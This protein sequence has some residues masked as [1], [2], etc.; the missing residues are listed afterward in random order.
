VTAGT[1]DNALLAS[2]E[3]VRAAKGR[4]PAI[5][6][7]SGT[8]L[9]TFAEI[10]DEGTA[11]AQQCASLPRGTIIALQLGNSAS[12]PAALLAV[13]RHELIA[14]PIGRHMERHETERA[15]TTATAGAIWTADGDTLRLEQRPGVL[16]RTWTGPT[17]H[18]LKLTSGTTS[19]PR[20]VRFRTPQ[21]LADCHQ[22]CSTM[23]ITAADLNFGVIPFSH[24]YG[25][26][27]LLTPLIAC[28]VPLVAS[29]DRLPRA[30][31]DG[32]AAT[33][34]SVFPGMPVFFQKMIELPNCPP[35]PA[36]RLCLSAGAPLSCQVAAEF[37]RRF[38]VKIHT[39][40]GASECGGIAFDRSD[41]PVSEEGFVGTAMD[42]VQLDRANEESPAPATIIVRSAAVSDGYDP[43]DE[44]TLAHGSF[45]P[46]DLIRREN[47]RL[48][49]T[50]RVSD[51][52]NVAGR[53]LNPFEVERCLE[54]CPG[55]RQAV[56]FGVTSALR[57]EEA[58]A[59]I[60]A[61]EKATNIDAQ[62][63]L[64]FCHTHL[65]GWQVPKDIW[66]LE[67]IPVNE[68]GKISRRLL[69]E[70]YPSR[71]AKSPRVGRPA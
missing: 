28:G 4:T 12:W 52:I 17:P 31:L 49:I 24:S 39:F 71:R 22:I 54:Q 34:A 16:P 68:R 46:A 14:L 37:R 67:S 38:N 26:S 57:G 1:R 30:I 55:V 65:S 59:C 69:A 70:C 27:N 35:L 15:L 60:V 50:G 47:E 53:K 9:R 3:R 40:Y 42:G 20:V 29:E 5:F 58:I 25:F 32:L 51:V 7:A 10:E 61:D 48:F 41:E 8:V 11:L 21:L 44:E 18:L 23:G 33:S 45:R 6:A 43:P 64:K 36:L 66:F 19:L 63:V 62:S 2:W 13:L 56:V